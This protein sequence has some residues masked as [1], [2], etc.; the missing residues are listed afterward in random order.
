MHGSGGQGAATR[1]LFS[2]GLGENGINKYVLYIHECTSVLAPKIFGIIM[3]LSMV[4][5]LK[6]V[7]CQV[8]ANSAFF[9][10]AFIG[11]Y[12]LL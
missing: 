2:S 9:G 12:L 10:R 4:T 1:I 7:L 11:S 3:A 6:V 8:H 5:L